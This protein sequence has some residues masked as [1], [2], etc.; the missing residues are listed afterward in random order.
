MANVRCKIR[1]PCK[2]TVTVHDDGKMLGLDFMLENFAKE[3][4]LN[5][6]AENVTHLLADSHGRPITSKPFSCFI[7]SL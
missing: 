4:C 7:A 6:L 1:A 5:R 3:F 2:S